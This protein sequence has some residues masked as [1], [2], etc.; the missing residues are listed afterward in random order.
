MIE[1]IDYEPSLKAQWDGFV[2]SA[3]NG[4]FLFQRDF[5][6]YHQDRFPDSSLMFLE[7]G[8]L[9]ALLPASRSGDEIVS[10]GGLTYGGILSGSDMSTSRMLAVFDAMLQKFRRDGARRLLYKAIPIFCHRHPA[11]EDLYALFRN[12]ARLVRRDAGFILRPSA[13]PRY[14]SLRERSLKK[15]SKAGLT[16]VETEDFVP[17][18]KMLTEVL[19]DRHEAQPVHTL[20]E[21]QLL[22]SR[23]PDQ[24]R[25]FVAMLAGET[26]AGTL[27]FEDLVFAHTQYIAA[28]PAGR[29]TR[30][31][32][33]VYDRLFTEIY[34]DKPWFSFGA[35]TEDQGRVLNAG[36]AEWKEGFGARATMLDFYAISL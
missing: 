9:V 3:K 33:L 17:Y 10:H 5:Q 14:S 35:A 19:R 24:I 28:G 12:D 29:E 6:D 31:L 8:R 32:D 15:A 26:V 18:W 16:L 23:F 1:A 27:V 25:L 11:Q 30:A 34:A 20:E 2:T 13:R 36:L 4:M 21:I 22:K 7:G